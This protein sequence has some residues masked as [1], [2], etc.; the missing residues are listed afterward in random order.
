[1]N[2][3]IGNLSRAML[4]AVLLVP[5]ASM[6]LNNFGVGKIA[7][8][9]QTAADAF[10]LTLGSPFELYSRAPMAA[11]L[12]VPGGQVQ[13]LAYNS[14]YGD[15]ELTEYFTT[16][17]AMDLAYPSGTYTITA[18]GQSLV[19][20]QLS[21]NLYPAPA[22]VINGA[23]DSS[24]N[25]LLDPSGSASI[26]VSPFPGYATTGVL[27]GILL[28][29]FSSTGTAVV[30][31]SWYSST[32][33]QAPASLPIP[34]GTLVAGQTYSG[35]LSYATYVDDDWTSVPGDEIVAYYINITTFQVLAQAPPSN[36]PVATSQ[37]ASQVVASGSTVVFSFSASGTPAPT[38]QWYLNGVAI[39]D[40]VQPSL[41]ISGATGANAGSYFCVA[42]NASGSAQ[43]SAATLSLSS[44][45]DVGR[46]V[47]ISCR[48]QVGTG[49]NILI[50]GF[51]VGGAGTSGT[52]Q[53]LVRGSGPALQPFG[54]AGTIAD[55]QLQ[56]YS[57][58][59]L[60][61]TN[62]GWGGGAAVASAAAS[63]GA[64]AWN[65][66]T[67]HDSALLETL[68]G[69]PY[70]A[71][72]AGQSGDT[73]VALAEVYDATPAGTYAPTS[74]RLVNISA[75]VQVGTGG[76]ILIAGFVIGGST[77]KTVLIRA[78]GPALAAFGVSGTLPDPSLQLYSGTTLLGS[79]SG[80]AGNMQIATAAASVGA[81]SWSSA[82]S[83]D[84][85]I[86][87]TLPPGAYTAQ[88]AGASGDTGV[89]LVEVYEVL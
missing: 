19:S 55:P 5:A 8:Y 6:A 40:A 4:T 30:S 37:P 50:A 52:E 85:A 74:P 83:N 49:G 80:W 14:T 41:V 66:P 62:N 58:S 18:P 89:A 67:S 24:G 26:T 65:V 61:G 44:T 75:R 22:T 31:S 35:A 32:T 13:Q 57:G 78:S 47:N 79:N 11:T 46:L 70:T 68:S 82:L 1:M 36:G 73:G 29:V 42:S 54:V 59:T 33:P 34:A 87:V 53:L 84:S 38:Y 86:L 63:V 72:I 28:D 51:A 77:S 17:A 27:G 3:R 60:L 81:F 48:A 15:Y 56:I 9:T 64:F 43:S 71:Q 23:W 76:G 69:G 25:L 39:P 88:V 12:G 20:L 16:Q 45:S 7:V 21:G 2:D 10:G